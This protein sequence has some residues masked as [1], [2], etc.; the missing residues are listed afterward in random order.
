MAA[1][2][3]RHTVSRQFEYSYIH[4]RPRDPSNQRYALFLHGW[5]SSA[6]EWHHQIEHFS[7]LGFGVVA[8]DCLGYGGTSCPAEVEHY[9]M[10]AIAQDIIDILDHEN[11]EQVHGIGHDFGCYLLGR[12]GV[13]FPER[14]VTFSFLGLS[15][16]PPGA[17]FDVDAVNRMT[18]DRFGYSLF[19]YMKWFNEAPDVGKL[20]DKHVRNLSLFV[21]SSYG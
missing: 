15:Y 2:V 20:L 17:F 5:P 12:L 16:R 4:V 3:S 19:G 11:I 10:K 6:H 8:P 7:E 14:F 1:L 18:A 21:R 9:R 13:Y